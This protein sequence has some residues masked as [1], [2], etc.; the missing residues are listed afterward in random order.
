[1]PKLYAS[2][3][4][5]AKA[6]EI[7][8]RGHL[9]QIMVFGHHDG[10][11]LAIEFGQRWCLVLGQHSRDPGAT[12]KQSMIGYSIFQRSKPIA[13]QLRQFGSSGL[14]P[15]T[16]RRTFSAVSRALVAWWRVV[17][18]WEGFPQP[19]LPKRWRRQGGPCQKQ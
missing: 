6:L 7:D 12:R 8:P 17:P 15:A 2:A 5:R 10:E 3:R 16:T 11:H 18:K 13:P 4:P 14:S 19:R 1:M 9:A